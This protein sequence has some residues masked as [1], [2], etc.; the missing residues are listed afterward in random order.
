[1][2]YADN[3]GVMPSSRYR[4]YTRRSSSRDN[5]DRFIP[6]RSAM[7]MDY[8]NWMAT[9]GWKE[10]QNPKP[11]SAKSE[12]YR[13]LLAEAMGLNRTRILAFKNKP[14]SADALELIPRS[15]TCSDSDYS[16]PAADK[17]RRHI[18][19]TPE[20]ELDLPGI[21]NNFYFNVLDW[22]CNNNI[23]AI[24]LGCIV[25]LWDASD[26]YISELVTVDEELGP[27]TS[28]NWA[29]DGF[30]LAIGLK[31]SQVQLW[32][33]AYEKLVQTLKGGHRQGCRV[34]SMA[35]NNNS[36]TTGGEDGRIVNN[37]IRFVDHTVKRCIYRGHNEDVCGLKWSDSGKHLA[38][39]GKDNLVH[40]WD[41]SMAA[42]GRTQYLHRLKGHTSTVKALAWSPFQRNLLATGGDDDKTVKFWNTD[43]G[44]CLNSVYTGSQVSALLWNKHERELLS[45]HGSPENQLTLWKYPS[46]VK[47]FETP[48]LTTRHLVMAQSPDGCTVA[49]A[50]GDERL[51]LWNVFGDPEVVK[52]AARKAARKAKFEPLSCSSQ[53]TIR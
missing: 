41:I 14:P 13:R 4:Y 32:D 7:D 34:L 30:H 38:S 48:G 37:D 17:P 49:S 31:N 47:L 23:V 40:I 20:R 11:I 22:G 43:T 5:L 29:P 36:L 44:A 50:A 24:A 26:G 2:V 12:L 8:A 28:V 46:M 6:N 18:R 10:E 52:K 16:K 3:L 33:C 25:Y 1:M 15:H 45:S 51:R 21:E 27:V 39:G 35:W 9:E 42:A 53:Y 19:Q